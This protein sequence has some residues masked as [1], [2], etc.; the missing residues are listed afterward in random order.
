MRI[1]SAFKLV[2]VVSALSFRLPDRGPKSRFQRELSR[3]TLMT[4]RSSVTV[5]QSGS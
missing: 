1:G 2:V 5:Q 3:S 4:W